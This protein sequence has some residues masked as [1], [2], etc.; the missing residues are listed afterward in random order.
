MNIL[1]INIKNSILSI[2]GL[3][4]AFNLSGQDLQKGKIRVDAELGTKIGGASPLGLP[5]EIRKI[6]GFKP[7]LPFFIGAKVTYGIDDNWGVQSGL[8]FEG[9][10]MKT[11]AT[12]KGY[13]TTFNADED[14][15]QNVRGYYY[16]DITTNVENL[17]LTI[18]V[19]ATYQLS[20]NW[21]LHAG[22]Y[23]SFA[24]QRKFY[25]LATDGYIRDEDPTG[26]KVGIVDAAYD[27]SKQIRKV[28]IGMSIGGKYD[29][30]KKF[31]A[32]AQ[33]D[34][35]F[36]SIMKTGF[37]SISFNMHNIFMNIGVGMRLF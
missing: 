30:N 10:G 26:E 15:S 11:E 31:Y 35:G 23:V 34:Y 29:I 13:R 37:E 17:Y 2:L 21:R 14:P 20:K 27:F 28:D 4:L 7:A 1:K 5:T 6:N 24:V 16:G 18:P 22:P 12:V 25:G 8:I 3:M 33:L 9:K 19:L 36:N 32:S